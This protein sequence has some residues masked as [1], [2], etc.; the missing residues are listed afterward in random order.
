MTPD[1]LGPPPSRPKTPPSPAVKALA[2]SACGAPL[3]VRAPGHSLSVVCA[4]CGSVLD[5]KDPD[6]TIIERHT[7]QTRIEPRIPL[8]SRGKIRGEIF[9]VIGFLV[10]QVTV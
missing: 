5:A 2:C 9:E 4:S 10:R 1:P 7:Q 6:F 8:G 3:K